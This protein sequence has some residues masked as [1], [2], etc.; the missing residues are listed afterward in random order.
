[1]VQRTGHVIKNT[2]RV[3]FLF[4]KVDTKYTLAQTV[5]QLLA[6]VL[7]LDFIETSTRDSQ[8]SFFFLFF[9]TKLRQTAA[10]FEIKCNYE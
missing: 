4:L 6:P 10:L 8:F 7:D 5:A 1:M 9:C 3:Q 2:A